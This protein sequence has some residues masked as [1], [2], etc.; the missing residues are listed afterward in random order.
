M[1]VVTGPT[2]SGKTSLAIDVAEHLGATLYNADP[3]QFYSE[4]RIISNRESFSGPSQFLGCFSLKDE[5]ISAGEFSR[6]SL[7]LLKENGVWVGCGLY[8]GA[9][10]YGLDADRRKGT[11]FQGAPRTDFKMI[12]LNPD[13][14]LLYEKINLRVEKMLAE[15][16]L[17]E[18]K[19]VFN[20][21]ERKEVSSTHPALKAIGLAHLLEYLQ[22]RQTLDQATEEWKQDTRRLA[23]RQWTW[24]RKF[25]PPSK[26]CHWVD[27]KEASKNFWHE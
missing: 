25:C 21:V 5:T 1:W 3:F 14:G 17:D 20:L 27:K 24:L 19:Q 6:R 12:V 15:G 9:L 22:G 16:A 13:R 4:L 11:P 26:M 8:V 7:D 2:A 23:K 10:L 18:A